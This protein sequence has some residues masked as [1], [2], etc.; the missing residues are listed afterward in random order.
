[1]RSWRCSR[2]VVKAAF[3][4]FGFETA[5]ASQ[6]VFGGHGYIREWGMEQYVRDARIAQIYEGTNGVQA[7]DLVSRKLGL[8]DG[9]LVAPLLRASSGPTL[10]PREPLAGEALVSPVADA[11]ARLEAATA[12]LAGAAPLESGAAATDY[13]RL[14]A[15]VAFG[16]MWARMAA[17]SAALGE[18]AT[19]VERSK[20]VLA[21]FFVE[22][23][24]P[25]TLALSGALASDAGPIMAL[26][27]EDL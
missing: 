1:M 20:T 25:Q 24:L 23:M 4:D 13:L 7:M 6:Q 15:L 18:A 19:P 11:L 16:W 2:P 27:P 12:R 8:D 26:Q 22:R 17:A 10:L 14:F 21:R 3:T 5:V 9:R